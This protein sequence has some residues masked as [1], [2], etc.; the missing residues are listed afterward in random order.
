MQ[1]ILDTEPQKKVSGAKA[2]QV[3][4]FKDF[5]REKTPF[6]ESEKKLQILIM[7]DRTNF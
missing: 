1:D 5:E 2:S 4:I 3:S 6:E 7:P